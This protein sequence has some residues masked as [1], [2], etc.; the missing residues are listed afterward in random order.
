MSQFTTEIKLLPVSEN[1]R[2]PYWNSTFGFEMKFSRI[3]IL[4]RVEFPILLLIFE[5]SL[6][7]RCLRCLTVFVGLSHRCNTANTLFPTVCTANNS[8]IDGERLLKAWHLDFVELY[9]D[10][11]VIVGIIVVSRCAAYI[12]MRLKPPYRTTAV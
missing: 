6:Q 11:L 5:W 8:Q 7:L 1:G 12:A 4:P 9:V 2:P 3:T 10:Y